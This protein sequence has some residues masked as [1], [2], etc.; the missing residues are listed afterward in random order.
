MLQALDG[1]LELF[2]C[3]HRLAQAWKRGRGGGH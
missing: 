1:W 3:D 2:G